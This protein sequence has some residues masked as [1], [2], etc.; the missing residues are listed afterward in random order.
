MLPLLIISTTDSPPLAQSEERTTKAVIY[1]AEIKGSREQALRV[2]GGDESLIIGVDKKTSAFSALLRIS[3]SPKN[4]DELVFLVHG[5]Y[6]GIK[7]STG[8]VIGAES[9]FW[10]RANGILNNSSIDIVISGCKMGAVTDP[11]YF[12]KISQ[13]VNGRVYVNTIDTG[14]SQI[15]NNKYYNAA[16][17][18]AESS[19]TTWRY[20]E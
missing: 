11:V 12:Q 13:S 14:T 1:D 6:D 15:W 8:E 9:G 7:F 2:A 5:S 18:G 16:P 19:T 3:G 20:F 4:I 17:Y 10:T